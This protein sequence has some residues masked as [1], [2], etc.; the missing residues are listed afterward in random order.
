MGL[1]SFNVLVLL[2]LL[3][4]VEPYRVNSRILCAEEEVEWMKKELSLQSLQKGPVPPSGS[5]GCTNIPGQGGPNCPNK[6][7][8]FAGNALPRSTVFP[9][10][11]VSF[12]V[13]TNQK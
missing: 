4:Y 6:E 8:H 2:L 13:A 7:M 10:L 1:H 11:M 3:L 9:R 12:G 5:S